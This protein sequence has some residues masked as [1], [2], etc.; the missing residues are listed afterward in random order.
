V[1][2]RIGVLRRPCA[3]QLPLYSERAVDQLIA[4][5]RDAL[6]RNMYPTDR[7]ALVRVLASGRDVN[8]PEIVPL[9]ERLGR[10][11]LGNPCARPRPGASPTP[12]AAA[13]RR[14]CASRRRQTIAANW[15]C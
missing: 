12:T 8:E 7:D 13:E 3:G 10:T 14:P 5:H 9:V 4:E 15:R 1:N 6:R 2:G 11:P